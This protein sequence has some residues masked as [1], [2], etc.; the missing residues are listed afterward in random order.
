MKIMKKINNCMQMNKIKM[1]NNKWM[2][3]FYSF[4][5]SKHSFSAMMIIFPNGISKQDYYNGSV[6]SN[7]KPM[8]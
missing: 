7:P 1:L 8:Q 4:L 2:V 5:I 3:N 6:K